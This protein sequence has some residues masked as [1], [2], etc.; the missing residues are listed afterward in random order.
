[1]KIST[2]IAPIT[3]SSEPLTLVSFSPSDCDDSFF[4]FQFIATADELEKMS[5]TLK[6]A[7]R[8]ARHEGALETQAVEGLVN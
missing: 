5:A 3:R 8:R 7:A 2:N 6:Q 1:M 4:V